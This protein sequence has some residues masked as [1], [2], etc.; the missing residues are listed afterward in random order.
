MSADG[1]I[2]LNPILSRP[3]RPELPKMGNSAILCAH[4]LSERAEGMLYYLFLAVLKSIA[5]CCNAKRFQA[6]RSKI[7]LLIFFW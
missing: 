1:S 7:L 3:L 5:N 6:L 4:F 2:F